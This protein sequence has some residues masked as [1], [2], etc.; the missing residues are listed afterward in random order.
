MGGW[1]LSPAIW[2]SPSAI[3]TRWRTPDLRERLCCA[4]AAMPGWTSMAGWSWTDTHDLPT[5]SHCPRV[6]GGRSGR[7]QC[8]PARSEGDCPTSPRR[9]CGNWQRAPASCPYSD[10]ALAPL[11]E[12]MIATDFLGKAPQ[13]PKR[14]KYCGNERRCRAILYLCASPLPPPRG[15]SNSVW[16]GCQLSESDVAVPSDSPLAAS[17]ASPAEPAFSST[18]H[19]YRSVSEAGW[20]IAMTS[21]GTGAWSGRGRATGDYAVGPLRGLPRRRPPAPRSRRCWQSG[22]P[23]APSPVLPPP[24]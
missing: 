8:Y 5:D 12:P 10:A 7:Q 23:A 21:S 14:G 6:G 17:L 24:R 13:V 1:R 19:E 22:G 20:A 18:A 9:G 15:D 16:T 4:L 11:C 2:A 3:T